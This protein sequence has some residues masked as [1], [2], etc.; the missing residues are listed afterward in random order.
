MEN[1]KKKLI[2]SVEKRRNGK[3]IESVGK[4]VT[5][6]FY[7]EYFNSENAL[8]L[9][10]FLKLK[11]TKSEFSRLKKYKNSRKYKSRKRN[12]KMNFKS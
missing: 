3:L 1:W 12:N 5:P 4:N 10:F 11:I 8:N 2:E 9:H 6:T 7:F